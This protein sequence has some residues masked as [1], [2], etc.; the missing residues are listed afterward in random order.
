MLLL[1]AVL[2]VALFAAGV[3]ADSSA[4]TANALDAFSDAMTYGVSMFAVTRSQRAKA[5][6]AG[7]TG[8]MLLVLAVGVVFDALRRYLTGSEPVGLVMMGMAALAVTVN[9]ICVHLLRRFRRSEVNLRA[10]WTMSLNDFA[11]NIG[12]VVA[13][14]LV[15]WLGANWP[16]LLLGL[17]I[18]TVA[19]HGGVKTL[20]E[21][22]RE[23]RSQSAAD[24]S[25][26]SGQRGN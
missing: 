20:R 22:W 19:S 8:V 14:A 11:S 17:L 7:I 1:N 26:A 3:L 21:A 13:G 2:A 10:A 24:R 15:A 23:G 25:G 12:I 16:D 4:L 6:A 5:L 9:A 18:A